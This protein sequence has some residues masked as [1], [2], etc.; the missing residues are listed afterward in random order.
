MYAARLPKT[1]WHTRVLYEGLLFLT[2]LYEYIEVLNVKT[3][4]KKA[5]ILLLHHNFVKVLKDALA[6]LGP[7][8]TLKKLWCSDPGEFKKSPYKQVLYSDS[9]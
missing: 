3:G 5:I 2:V 4:V 8:Q 6:R 9:R 7:Y 1:S